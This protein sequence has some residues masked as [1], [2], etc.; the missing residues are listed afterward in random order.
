MPVAASGQNHGSTNSVAPAASAPPHSPMSAVYPFRY[1]RRQHSGCCQLLKMILVGLILFPIRA[2]IFLIA[3]FNLWLTSAFMLCCTNE[4]TLREVP[5]S[6]PIGR[7][8]LRVWA[9][10]ILWCFGYWWI[11]TTHVKRDPKDTTSTLPP[12][13]R[14]SNKK[15]PPAPIIAANHCSFIDAFYFAYAENPMAVAKAELGRAPIVGTIT[16]AT[17]TVFVS[18][19]SG[20]GRHNVADEIKRRTQWNKTQTQET[21]KK[22]G[23]WPPL[24]IF[25]EATCTNTSSVIQFK[26]GAF[27]PMMPV[28]PV[29]L[30]YR[31]S[32][33][34]AS[35]VGGV[36]PPITMLRMMCQIYNKLH[37]TYLPIEYPGH[38]S[39]GGAEVADTP[40]LFAERVRVKIAEALKVPLTNH[41]FLDTLLLREVH[42]LRLPISA[43][44]VEMGNYGHGLDEAKKKLREFA[45]LD[46]NGD[47]VLDREEFAA[48]LGFSGSE[49]SES[50]VDALLAKW[51]TDGDGKVNFREFLLFSA[52]L[53]A[54]HQ[55]KK[56]EGVQ[57]TEAG[58]PRVQKGDV[59]GEEL[60][61][62][63]ALCFGAFDEDHDGKVHRT[64][65]LNHVAKVAPHVQ[66][67]EVQALFDRVDTDSDGIVSMGEYLEFCNKH[68]FLIVTFLDALSLGEQDLLPAEEQETMEAISRTNTFVAEGSFDGSRRST[69]TVVS[70]DPHEA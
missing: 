59:D 10:I 70:P 67:S 46:K 1:D 41:N 5:L 58:S 24:L 49:E 25:P 6:R 63:F 29:A 15:E 39:A 44:N 48:L 2:V 21:L 57:A 7:F 37:V 55:V 12:E 64:E 36:N 66:N 9:R 19:E 20:P 4:H 43:G 50:I 60:Q 35:W 11:S 27:Q 23:K 45:A 65:F 52:V 17:Q 62:A 42:L 33:L 30:D 56:Q 14:G 13:L 34:D 28:Q 51:D 8:L 18:R 16:R 54:R 47:G 32:H 31:Q 69:P 38:P 40:Q 3:F 68:P 22:L 53:K 61:Q 26:A